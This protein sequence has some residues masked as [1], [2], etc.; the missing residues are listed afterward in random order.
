MTEMVYATS[1]RDFVERAKQRPTEG[2]LY[3][4]KVALSVCQMSKEAYG[5]GAAFSQ[6]AQSTRDPARAQQALHAIATRCE[7]LT[8]ADFAQLD[9]R[10]KGLRAGRQEDP[11]LTASDRLL[12]EKLDQ[13]AWRDNLQTLMQA[14]AFGLGSLPID[15]LNAPLE[16]GGVAKTP[17][18]NGRPYGGVSPDE[19]RAVMTIASS[20]AGAVR[21][22]KPSFEVLVRCAASGICDEN[23]S[24]L[25]TELARLNSRG[26]KTT[27]QELQRV[28]EAY[29][30][31]IRQGSADAFLPPARNG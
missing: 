3:F 11:L 22:G 17:Y 20:T 16:S 14:G 21:D 5:T 4:A 24:P 2:G 1:L 18:L 12:R 25:D 6:Q 29:Q 10:A 31:A 28:V 13:K 9:D 23:A 15:A 27:R 7:G 30:R 26:L 19:F 8:D